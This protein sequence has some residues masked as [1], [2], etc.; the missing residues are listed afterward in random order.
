[1]AQDRKQA[2]I[3]LTD[4]ET[5]ELVRIPAD[6]LERWKA[7]QRAGPQKASE[8]EKRRLLGRLQAL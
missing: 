7:V 6:R 5:G 8:E 4:K 2:S 3:Y 1:M